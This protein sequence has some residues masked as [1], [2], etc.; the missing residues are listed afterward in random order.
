MTKN[1]LQSVMLK[2]AMKKNN[3]LDSDALIEKIKHGYIIN[4]GPK[5]TQKKTFAPSTIAYSHGECPRY[6]YLAFDG[7]MFED[8]ADAYAAANMTAGTLS[9]ARIQNAMMNAGIVKVYRD[10]DNEPTTEFKI[11]HD[12]PPIFGYGDVMFDWQ[13]EELILS[14]IHISEPRDR[15]K[16]RMPSSA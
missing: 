15:Q 8:N 14:L 5:Q 4:R 12:D 11:R 6:W 3:I 2:P 9:H 16:S 13:G 1:L 7:Q 10:D